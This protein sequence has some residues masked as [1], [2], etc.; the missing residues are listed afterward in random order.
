ML[1]AQSQ[2]NCRLRNLPFDLLLLNTSSQS[3]PHYQTYHLRLRWVPEMKTIALFVT[4]KSSVKL[5]MS[6][7]IERRFKPFNLRQEVSECMGCHHRPLV[8]TQKKQTKTTQTKK[9]TKHGMLNNNVEFC[10]NDQRDNK[11]S[12]HL[13]PTLR[14]VRRVWEVRCGCNQTTHPQK[15][16]RGTCRVYSKTYWVNG[17][18]GQAK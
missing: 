16:E 14:I 17:T 1:I 10:K 11:I 6:H 15:K 9:P 4:T 5:Q 18:F 3:N 13:R 8:I 2:K 12:R 7:W